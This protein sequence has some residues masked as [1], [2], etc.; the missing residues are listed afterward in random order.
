M[1]RGVEMGTAGNCTGNEV[2]S[3]GLGDGLRFVGGGVGGEW[4]VAEFVTGN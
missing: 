2:V 1:E 3:R 4:N